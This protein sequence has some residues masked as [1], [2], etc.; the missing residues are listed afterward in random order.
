LFILPDGSLWRWGQFGKDNRNATVPEP[1]QP[2]NDWIQAESWGV[3]WLGLRKDGTI[4]EQRA[5][6]SSA[7]GS[8]DPNPGQPDAGH[9]WVRITDRGTWCFA[10]KRDGTL[11]AWSAGGI[12]QN[13]I[14][15]HTN[16]VQIGTNTDWA[17]VR[18]NGMSALALRADGSLWVMGRIWLRGSNPYLPLIGGAY[19]PTNLPVPLQVCRETNWVSL[20]ND[21]LLARNRQGELWDFFYSPPGEDQ[22]AVAVGRLFCTNAVPDHFA[23][24]Y[25]GDYKAFQIHEDGTLWER[26][27]PYGAD[28][29]KP[30]GKLHQV[31]NRQDWSSL[32]S[33]GGTAY[34]LTAD[35]TL[36]TWGT[37]PNL[38]PVADLAAEFRLL[39]D[40]LN[41]TTSPGTG[42]TTKRPQFQK[43][44]RPLMKFDTA[45]P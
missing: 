22:G 37:D 40:R 36:W 39:Q 42:L 16:L 29:G 3:H 8:S 12:I 9:D 28:S 31:G 11:W 10:I 24:A 14:P 6:Y 1:F 2:G 35:G 30:V 15:I 23:F 5:N 17:D 34:G 45:S 26:I 4:W 43:A 32:W 33:G 44:P 7:V 41:G 13:N 18:G 19:S 25:C 27:Q 20:M 21:T 38:E